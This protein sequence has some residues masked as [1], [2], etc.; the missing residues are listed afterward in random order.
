MMRFRYALLIAAVLLAASAIAGV[1]QPQL[2]RSAAKTATTPA[3]TITVSGHGTVMTVPDRGSF[4]FT[5]DTRAQTAAGA[6]GRN[7]D[8]ATAVVAA[9]KNAG[10]AA[11]DIQTSQVYLS[12]QTSQNGTSIIGYAASTSIVVKTTIAKAGSIIDAAVGAGA[13]GVSGPSLSRSDED[14]LYRDAL[15]NAVSD[16]RDKAA[17][18]AS[19]A[20][21]TL[22][23]A[24]TVVEGGGQ[25]PIPFAAGAKAA[26]SSVA[27]EPG[28]QTIEA[29]VTVTYSAS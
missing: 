10:V 13:D 3:K 5:V 2:G 15:K 25:A 1:A 16:A 19:A 12:P 4:Y 9:L 11:A 20:G 28:T 23:G 8:A 29:N 14:A 22:G 27:I 24:Q 6:L 18:L 21:L 26:D 17:A 7:A